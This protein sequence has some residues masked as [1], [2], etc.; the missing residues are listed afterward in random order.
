MRTREHILFG[1]ILSHRFKKGGQKMSVRANLK[2]RL[3]MVVFLMAIG[4]GAAVGQI[5]YV[6][7]DGAAEFD[8]IQAAIDDSNDGDTIIVR[9]GTYT[10]DGNRD[11]DFLGKAITV[12]SENGPDNCI[13][14]CQGSETEPHRGFHFHSGEAEDSV[15]DGFTITN[16]YAPE[17]KMGFDVQPC[18]GAI[19][20]DGSSPTITNCIIRDNAGMEGIGGGICCEDSIAM[21]QNCTIS[22]N[23]AR[24]GGGI[25]A[26]C[27]VVVADCIITSNYVFGPGG[28]TVDGGGISC[29]EGATIVNCRIT[30][31]RARNG[32]GIRCRRPCIIRNCIF[33][34]NRA[35]HRGGGL[36]V[37][38]IWAD[39]LIIN[40]TLSGNRSSH[41]GGID[42][43]SCNAKVINCILWGN[44]AVFGPEMS[45]DGFYRPSFLT[46]S[47]SNIVGGE[48]AVDVGVEVTLVWGDGNIDIDPCFVEPGYWDANNT[49][50]DANDDF[51]VDGDYHLQSQAGRWDPNSEIWV[52][53]SN[54]SPSIDAGN[55]G[56][57][58]GDEPNDPHNIRINM[59]AYGGTAEASKSPA[60]W[61]NIADLTND[62][63]VDFNDLKVFVDY[64]LET[65]ECI[66]SDLNRSQ[67]VDFADFALVALHW[68][69]ER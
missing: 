45:I 28:R 41:G 69:E 50:D 58:L 14:D 21:I 65:G 31:N 13:I 22:N 27:P 37:M 34:G 54:T 52:V 30:D 46:T 24:Q 17:E 19:C 59:G 7:Y 26:Y 6:D 35:E 1:Q 61:R 3:V 64:W 5:I 11:I 29:G 60:N 36:G 10:G 55:P 12:R 39:S 33:T 15:L 67:S 43:Q 40:C 63:A 2:T 18:G 8:N 38:S 66:P 47:Y 20:C 68:L 53:D 49:P 4:G 57:P 42:C 32:G 25:Y 51:W 44:T 23:W 9:D 62:W 48:G 56:C 16:G